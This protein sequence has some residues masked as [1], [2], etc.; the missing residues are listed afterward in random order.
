M[1]EAV[2]IRELIIILIRKLI[3]TFL[4]ILFANFYNCDCSF[5]LQIHF[6]MTVILRIIKPNYV[7]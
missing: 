2:N 5:T 3:F 7:V 4:Y 1:V 6:Q